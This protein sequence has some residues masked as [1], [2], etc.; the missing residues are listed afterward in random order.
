MEDLVIVGSSGFAK[1]IRALI[2][3]LDEYNFLGYIDEEVNKAEVI[4]NDDFLMVYGKRL[5]VVIAI[6]NGHVRR[7]L[8]NQYL[9]N[10][11]LIFPN[12]IDKNALFLEH[13]NL[14]QGNI[15]CAGS[16]ITVDVSLGNFNIINLGCTIGHGV[17]ISD[18]VT[19]NPSVNVSGDVYIEDMVNI[20]TG[21]QILQG[22]RIEKNTI[23]GA[24]AVV[25]KDLPADCTAVG[26]PAKVIKY[27]GEN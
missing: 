13:I 22:K 17:N 9:N 2:D 8:Y 6:G 24:G 3:R 18:F 12:V 11:N 1:E 16:I 10:T 5:N 26:V 4:G 19:L 20:G 23:V 25:V 27:K 15:I 7:R 14:G 21:T